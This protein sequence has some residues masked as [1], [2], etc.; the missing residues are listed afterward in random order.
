MNYKEEYPVGTRVRITGKIE[1]HESITPCEGTIIEHSS[2][3]KCP[4]VQANHSLTSIF[5]YTHELK[6]LEKIE[7]FKIGD[8]IQYRFH[9]GGWRDGFYV[10]KVTSRFLCTENSCINANHGVFSVFH[11]N[12]VR[13]PKKAEYTT[14][15][16]REFT[17]EELA[18]LAD[19]PLD[20]FKIKGK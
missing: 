15:E 5:F 12:E 2:M 6:Y 17:I 16:A 3:Y 19:V 8:P 11:C 18:K 4:I 9:I 10:G 7:E 20:E 1:G 14:T 13:R